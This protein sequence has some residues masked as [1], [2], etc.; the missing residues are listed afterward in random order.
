MKMTKLLL[1]TMVLGFGSG[2]NANWGKDKSYKSGAT[3]TEKD[4]AVFK[5]VVI[6]FAPGSSKI[7]SSDMSVLKSAIA[8]AKE[9]GR[10]SKVQAAVWSDKSLPRTGELSKVD[11]KL[12]DDRIDSIKTAV[13]DETSMFKKVKSY[14]MSD[15]THWLGRQFNTDEAELEAVFAKNERDAVLREDFD[16]I[17]REGGPSKAVV[18]LKVKEKIMDKM[19]N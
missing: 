1:L 18:I 3:K 17:K 19:K 5:S 14:D 4:D 11:R 16:I 7:S 13:H 10:I 12:A 15:S 6:N 2:A 9:K 8:D